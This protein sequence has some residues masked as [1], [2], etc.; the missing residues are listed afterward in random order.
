MSAPASIWMPLY[1]RDYNNDTQGLDAEQSGAYLHLLMY[2]WTVDKPLP[3][4]DRFLAGVGRVPLHRWLKNVK[5]RVIA[6]FQRVE[7]GFRQK[8]L[9]EEREKALNKSE[10]AKVGGLNSAQKKKEKQ[11]PTG[12]VLAV[13]FPL[14]GNTVQTQIESEREVSK[15]EDISLPAV[16]RQ[17][18]ADKPVRKPVKAP[19]ERVAEQ[20][21]TELILEPPKQVE[22][23]SDADQAVAGWNATARSHG[24]ATVREVTGQRRDKLMKILR[25]HGLEGWQQMLDELATCPWCQGENDRGWR[26]DFDFVMRPDKFLKVLEG[27]F[28][29]GRGPKPKQ[30]AASALPLAE[31]WEQDDA[32]YDAQVERLVGS[33]VLEH[34]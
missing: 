8:R 29:R 2:S 12:K 14:N 11:R 16:A 32:A 31:A 21:G 7:G 23:V 25:R 17:P 30:T 15:E 10:R 4:D 13:E 20:P 27:G 5:D 19:P 24:L 18:A 6:F 1:I 26:V 9:E 33:R 34:V 3:D 28:R 22:K